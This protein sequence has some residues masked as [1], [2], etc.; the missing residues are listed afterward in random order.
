M[1]GPAR[2]HAII[3]GR[4]QGVAFRA[5]AEERAAAYGLTGYVQNLGNGDIE[6]VAEGDKALLEEFL[7]DVRKGPVGARVREV[8]VNWEGPRGEFREFSIR[9]G[10]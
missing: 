4:V 1:T 7:A 9:F 3:R 10:W 6:V 8:I 5:F 2:F